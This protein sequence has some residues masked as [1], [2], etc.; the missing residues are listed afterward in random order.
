MITRD[1]YSIPPSNYLLD[2]YGNC[3]LNV[4]LLKDSAQ[5]ASLGQ[6]F[7]KT[8]YTSLNYEKNFVYF[9][10]S[11]TVTV[12]GTM[13]IFPAI[14]VIYLGLTINIIPGIIAAFCMEYHY[15][16]RIRRK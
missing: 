4:A 2:S 7:V 10:V 6:P 14:L 9:G 3:F 13:K 8:F 12:R 5:Y 16:P 15:C 11:T 1:K